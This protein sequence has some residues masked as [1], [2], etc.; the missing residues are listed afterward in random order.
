MVSKS[1]PNYFEVFKQF[2]DLLFTVQWP[3]LLLTD[4]YQLIDVF[5]YD[6]FEVVIRCT[7]GT[8]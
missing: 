1:Q 3:V 6:E 8:F 7:G 4:I 5:Y 2:L